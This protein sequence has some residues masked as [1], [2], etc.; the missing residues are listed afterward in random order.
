MVCHIVCKF[1]GKIQKI[2]KIILKTQFLEE[3]GFC[4]LEQS[5]K[6]WH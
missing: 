5:N 6:Y 3:F 2:T 4:D 1:L